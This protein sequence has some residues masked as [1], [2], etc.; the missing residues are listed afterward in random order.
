MN[1]IYIYFENNFGKKELIAKVLDKK[2]VNETV[3]DYLNCLDADT[4][5][6]IIITKS[7]LEV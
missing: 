7:K 4:S 2:L 5:R 1:Y 6:K 3:E